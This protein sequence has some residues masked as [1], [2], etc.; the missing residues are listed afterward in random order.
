[1]DAH[2]CYYSTDHCVCRQLQGGGAPAAAHPRI[3]T[4]SAGFVL[5]NRRRGEGWQTCYYGNEYCHHRPELFPNTNLQWVPCIPWVP[6]V[7]S[8][9]GSEC[10]MPRSASAVWWGG[11]AG[12]IKIWSRY[13]LLVPFPPWPSALKKV[14]LCLSFC[15][16]W[17]DQ[18]WQSY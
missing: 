12:G 2:K 16:V 18:P 13:L 4:D 11:L 5:N 10:S 1:M 7:S 15:L 8:R 6:G 14:T 17:S 3:S 9:S